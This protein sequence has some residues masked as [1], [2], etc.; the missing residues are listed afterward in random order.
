MNHVNDAT[1]L[2]GRQEEPGKRY[3]LWIERALLLGAAA[4]FFLYAA[5]VSAAI[6][7]PILGTLTAYVVYPLVLLALVEMCGRILQN[8]HGS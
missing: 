5:D 2:T 3:P 1:T 6:D 7:Q 8:I 4:V